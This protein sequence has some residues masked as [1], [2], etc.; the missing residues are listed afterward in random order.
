MFTWEYLI[1][2]NL[3]KD[4][5][6]VADLARVCFFVPG[7]RQTKKSCCKRLQVSFWIPLMVVLEVVFLLL[8]WIW[9]RTKKST[10]SGMVLLFLGFLVSRTVLCCSKLGFGWGYWREFC[11]DFWLKYGRVC[12]YI[13]IQMDACRQNYGRTLRS[14]RLQL[15]CSIISIV[16]YRH[17]IRFGFRRT[18]WRFVT[19]SNATG[20]RK[21]AIFSG[22]CRRVALV[23][24]VT[25][26]CVRYN[27]LQLNFWS[28]QLD[29][30]VERLAQSGT[31][32]Q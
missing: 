3:R 32:G 24:L 18:S 1:S 25:I 31:L 27:G 8:V 28:Y 12:I 6:S 19:C 7:H 10:D 26:D 17:K 21:A 23:T 22:R 16:Q 20:S 4:S 5:E 14:A 2:K 30:S 29:A 9:H 15:E 11:A 13:Y